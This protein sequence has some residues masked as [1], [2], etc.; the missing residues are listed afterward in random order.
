MIATGK[1]PEQPGP[2]PTH[3]LARTESERVD[4]IPREA[5][6][7]DARKRRSLLS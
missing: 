1:G 6:S 5:D 7:G 4:A 2:S 3:S